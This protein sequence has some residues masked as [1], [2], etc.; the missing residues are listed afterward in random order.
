MVNTI[1][2]TWTSTSVCYTPNVTN[3]SHL[4][5]DGGDDTPSI[6]ANSGSRRAPL[7]TKSKP[8]TLTEVLPFLS[9]SCD[10][11][12]SLRTA[13]RVPPVTPRSGDD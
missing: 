9:K 13:N 11:H 7:L 5:T 6:S 4:G 1:I 10:N 3:V 8:F 2:H 12:N